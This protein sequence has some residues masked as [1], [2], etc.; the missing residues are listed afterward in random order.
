M[1]LVELIHS[2]EY[3]VEKLAEIID[4]LGIIGA[5]FTIT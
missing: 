3:L 2:S 1:E 5:I 4:S